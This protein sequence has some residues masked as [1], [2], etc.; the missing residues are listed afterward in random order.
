MCAKYDLGDL[1]NAPKE[2]RAF[3]ETF[4]ALIFVGRHNHIAS[5]LIAAADSIVPHGAWWVTTSII[6]AYYVGVNY[7]YHSPLF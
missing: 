7:L 3:L 2:T 6:L 4:A 1:R 5:A